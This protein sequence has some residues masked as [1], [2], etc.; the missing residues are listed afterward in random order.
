[1]KMKSKFEMT[2]AL[3][4]AMFLLASSSTLGAQSTTVD[5]IWGEADP[6]YEIW[7]VIS[8][9]GGH[10]ASGDTFTVE[11]NVTGAGIKL[12]PSPGLRSKWSLTN[13]VPLTI[14]EIA[15]VSALCG[16]VMLET[17]EHSGMQYGHGQ[18]HGILLKVQQPDRIK[19]MWSALPLAK[20]VPNDKKTKT[21]KCKDFE[22]LHHG[23]VAHA[24]SK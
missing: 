16:F 17:V 5:I 14:E 24:R 12:T 13:D 21:K 7:E 18:Q 19:I 8:A 10:M 9:T 23:G 3:C 11:R 1:M 15:G 22:K 20:E 2:A 4:L 6:G